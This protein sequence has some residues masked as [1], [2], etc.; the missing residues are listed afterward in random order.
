MPIAIKRKD[1]ITH[2]ARNLFREKGYSATT[3]RDLAST[4]GIE[5]A[6]LYAHVKS[7][8]SIL[9]QICFNMADQ[10]MAITVLVGKEKISVENKLILAI[11]KHVEVI[12]NNTDASAV[13]L[14]D[15]KHLSEPHLTN[16]KLMRN[17]YELFYVDLIRSGEKNK[18][19]KNIDEKFVTMTLFSAM[20]WMYDYYK[21][22]GKMK[23]KEIADHLAELILK[24]LKN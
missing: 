9:Q 8:E 17:K 7:K 22:S 20:N 11:E 2:V 12:V 10:F 24:G 18:T 23:P 4:V 6:S 21:P 13:F 14:H 5:A 3:M 19:F 1:H 16:F 15:W